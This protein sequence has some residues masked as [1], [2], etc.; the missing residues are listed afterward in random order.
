MWLSLCQ[1]MSTVRTSRRWCLPLIQSVEIGPRLVQKRKIKQFEGRLDQIQQIQLC[2][3]L[4]WKQV[5]AQV[6][7]GP[8][9]QHILA[10]LHA[11]LPGI[12]KIITFTILEKNDRPSIWYMTKMKKTEAK[13]KLSRTT[14]YKNQSV[15]SFYLE[16][17][18]VLEFRF[19]ELWKW[20]Y[21]SFWLQF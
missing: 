21:L 15:F 18:S 16:C 17:N 5:C 6:R 2:Q 13:H 12:F 20:G 8:D 9:L 4:F 11:E 7:K 1:P 3:C 10:C 19:P 14:C